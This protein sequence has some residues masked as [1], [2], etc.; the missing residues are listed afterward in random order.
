MGRSTTAAAFLAGVAV[1]ALV[2]HRSG[3]QR[4]AP[5]IATPSGTVSPMVR[6]VESLPARPL[7][8]G[9]QQ[10]ASSPE[11]DAALLE[12]ELLRGQL[13]AFGGLPVLDWPED[14]PDALLPEQLEAR[15]RAEVAAVPG[16]TLEGMD[17]SE[18][19]CMALV[20]LAPD[21]PSSTGSVAPALAWVETAAGHQARVSME[22]NARRP[23]GPQD[24]V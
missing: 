8:T 20:A 12:V 19:P 9:Q 7:S 5:A 22:C 21:L 13:A 15:M 18:F 24:C 11:L 10:E 1:G 4:E 6:A 14:L 2:G 17:C 3:A 16:L 23:G